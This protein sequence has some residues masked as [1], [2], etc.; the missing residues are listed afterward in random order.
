MLYLKREYE[1][2]VERMK[3][4]I[5]AGGSGTRLYP[6]TKGINKQL[7]PV[8]DKPMIYYPLSVLMLAGIREVLVITSLKDLEAYKNLLGNGKVLGITIKYQ[9]QKESNGLTEAFI[10]GEEFIGNDC[11]ALILGDNIF[12]GSFFTDTL[13]K[14]ISLE[15][16][17][18][19]FGYYVKKPK[20]FG[21]VEFDKE[22]KVVSLEEK[23]EMPKSNFVVPG[24][25]FYDNTVVEKAKGLKPSERGELEI[26]DINKLYLQEGTLECISL[27]R[28][29]AWLDT[30]TF[31]G[32]VDATNFVKAIQ[33][34][35]GI[36]IACLEEIAYNKR[37]I[38]REQL[39]KIA[40]PLGKTSYGEYLMGLAK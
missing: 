34:R 6:V 27:G 23:P 28:G 20:E 19:V 15:R 22:G 7:L 14:C 16:G 25:Y 18:K 17:A 8:Y 2:G 38:S 39:I 1:E 3:G 32:L 4:I 37:W 10:I 5:M 11:V 9:I 12:Y 31:D 26:T 36:M 40:E 13:K 21:V 35:Q 24:L 33:D 29:M 30:G